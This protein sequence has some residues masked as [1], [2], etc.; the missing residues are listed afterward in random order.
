M[1]T[2]TRSPARCVE[3]GGVPPRSFFPFDKTMTTDTSMAPLTSDAPKPKGKT[4][5]KLSAKQKARKS[6]KVEKALATA[7]KRIEKQRKSGIKKET[8]KVLKKLWT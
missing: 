1:E 4:Q 7:S 3:R 6:K 8:K 2:L 5:G